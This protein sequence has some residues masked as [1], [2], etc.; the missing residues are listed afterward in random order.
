MH[1]ILAPNNENFTDFAFLVLSRGTK[2]FINVRVR[3]T[4][5]DITETSNFPMFR[6]EKSLKKEIIWYFMFLPLLVLSKPTRFVCEI[7]A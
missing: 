2:K 1:R 7:F 4:D 6:L 5:N 3:D